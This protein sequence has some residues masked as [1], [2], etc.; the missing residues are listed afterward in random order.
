MDG[1]LEP[2][3]VLS[4]LSKVLPDDLKTLNSPH[5][6]LAGLVHALHVNLGFRLTPSHDVD[7][8]TE[9]ERRLAGNKLPDGWGQQGRDLSLAYRHASSAMSF[10]SG[11]SKI[12]GRVIVNALAVEVRLRHS[13]YC[14][15]R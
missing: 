6:A 13:F 12:G 14:R 5:V 7:E 1:E 11:V 4:T 15:C 3:K 10:E 9:E 2:V 8:G